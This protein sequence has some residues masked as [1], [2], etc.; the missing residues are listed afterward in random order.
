MQYKLNIMIEIIVLC[1]V[2]LILGLYILIS[3]A[4]ERTFVEC[5]K[6]PNKYFKK[7]Y[8]EE[9]GKYRWTRTNLLGA[10]DVNFRVDIGYKC[11]YCG[12]IK[13]KPYE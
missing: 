13:V 2:L 7:H 12:K 9:T 8:W 6:N 4:K 3:Y 5:E 11:K 1:I 10:Y